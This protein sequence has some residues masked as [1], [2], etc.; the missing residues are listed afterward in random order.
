MGILLRKLFNTFLIFFLISNISLSQDQISK[1]L[2]PRNA[3]YDITVTLDTKTKTLEGSE[4]LTWT[5]LSKENVYELQFHLYLNAFKNSNSTFMKESRTGVSKRNRNITVG[6]WGW[7]DISTMKTLDGKDLTDRIKFIQPDDDNIDDQTVISVRLDEPVRPGRS[8]QLK[9]DFTSKLPKVIART[10]YEDDFF[11]VAQWFPKLGVY[12]FPGIRNATKG[13]WNCHQFHANSEFYSDFGVYNVSITLP[14][15]FI[16]GAVGVLQNKKENSDSTITYKYKAED[17][18]DFAW[19]ASPH[20]KVFV[21]MW[22]NVKLIILMQPEHTSLTPRVLESL[23]G[24]LEYFSNNLGDYPYPI[25]TVVDP[26]LKGMEAGGM[27][28]PGFFTIVSLWNLPKGI[29]FLEN[30]TV[31]EFGHTYFM[32]ILASNEFEDPWLDEGFNSYYEARTMDSLYGVKTSY[33]DFW[34]YNYGTRENQR[35]SY[36]SM[37]NPQIANNYRT[38]WEFTNGGYGVITYSKTGTWMATLEGLVGLDV[39]NEIMKTYY[40]RWKFKHPSAQNFIDIVNEI[41][42]KRLGNKYGK[43]LNWFFDQFLYG[44]AVCDYKVAKITNVEISQPRG[45]YDSANVKKSFKYKRTKEKNYRSSFL[46]SRLGDAIMPTEIEV[47][48]TDN[49]DTLFIWDGKAQN[50]NFTFEGKKQIEWVKLDPKDK[51]LM[52]INIFNNS[53]TTDKKTTVINKYFTKFLYLVEN[54]MLSLSMLF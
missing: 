7:I 20:F 40:E 4:V 17:A 30:V 19:T 10:G 53:L 21:D 41:Y 36:I 8:I 14:D 54:I 26:P 25:V 23:K 33:V 42:V 18:V 46:V 22:N 47:H 35:L 24:S 29:R 1:Q 5:N 52:D 31:H 13:G 51:N 2:S 43:N 9:I 6:D 38:S 50:K 49:T 3:N 32:G 28:Y 12:E 45:I 34:G 39:M 11:L 48:F 37:K 44:T 16:V 15:N 27:E